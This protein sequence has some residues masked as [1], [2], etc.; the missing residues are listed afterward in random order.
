M[1]KQPERTLVRLTAKGT[2]NRREYAVQ[3]CQAG[4][5]RRRDNILGNW[6]IPPETLRAAVHLLDSVAVFVDHAVGNFFVDGYPSLRDLAGVTF[7]PAW[8]DAVQAIVGGIRLYSVA[9][10]L[11]VLLDE[12][13]TDQVAGKETPDVGLSLVFYGHT[14]ESDDGWLTTDRIDYIESCDIVFGP[15]A[16]GRIKAALSRAGVISLH[17]GETME[18]KKDLAQPGGPPVVVP[19]AEPKLDDVIGKIEKLAAIVNDQEKERQQ[20]ALAALTA[21]VDELAIAVAAREERTAVRGMG[22]AP[23]ASYLTQR[24]ELDRF[25]GCVDWL[26]GAPGAPM[27]DPQMRR[28][29]SIYRALTGDWEMRGKFDRERVLLASATTTTLA[30]LAVNAMNKV[31]LEQFSHLTAWRWYER[32][33]AVTPNDGSLQNM[34]WISFGGLGNLPT[35]LEGGPYT[36]LTTADMKEADSFVK[37]GG[38]VGITREMIKNSDLLRIQ[39]VPRALAIAALR[40]R[41][42]AVSYIFT[43]A[44]G[45]G[46]TLEQDSVALFNAGSHYNHSTVAF[47]AAEWSVVRAAIFQQPEINS[48]KALGIFPKYAL[49]PAELY[50]TALIAFGYGEGMPTTYAPYSQD[51]GPDDPRPVPLVVPDWIDYTDWAAI[52]DP[53]VFP[54]IMMTYSQQPGGGGHPAPELFSVVSEESGLMFT[55]DVL[56]IKVRDEFA[57]GPNGWRGIFKEVVA[58]G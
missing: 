40:T 20:T 39:A 52:V 31:I 41:S 45:L 55:N 44:A 14:A 26:F 22:V 47:S 24:T 36:E 17:G 15:G 2:S 21:K 32:I 56:P 8:D 16:E 7:A 51:R 33:V 34:Q 11:Q 10:W 28:A 19:P 23:V 43:Q 12:V 25:A 13:L 4:Q 50:D 5:I 53:V 54:V 18:E 57:V 1:V 37:K 58:G 9:D 49:L 46:P 48:G 30:D 6:T 42:A 35:V 27:P 38:Y 29:D 3:F